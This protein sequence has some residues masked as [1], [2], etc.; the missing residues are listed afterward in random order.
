MGRFVIEGSGVG[1][2][3]PVALKGLHEGLSEWE[4]RLEGEDR[5]SREG[6]TRKMKKWK[7]GEAG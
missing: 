1:I 4:K 2:D 5:E 7:E 3:D 6:V